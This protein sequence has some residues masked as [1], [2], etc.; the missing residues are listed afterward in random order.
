[1]VIKL[2]F[3]NIYLN[4]LSLKI[5][6]IFM[7]YQRK[8]IITQNLVT[9]YNDFRWKLKPQS[10]IYYSCNALYSSSVEWIRKRELNIFQIE[11]EHKL[12]YKKTYS[13]NTAIYALNLTLNL[14]LFHQII[15]TVLCLITIENN[16]YTHSRRNS[17][18]KHNNYFHRYIIMLNPSL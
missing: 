1:M 13:P 17:F 10:N 5:I 16:D 11:S 18:L 7:S 8:W 6:L 15:R 12:Q 2:S 4:L 9:L 14:Q 3:I